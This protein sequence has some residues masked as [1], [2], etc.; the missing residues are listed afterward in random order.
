MLFYTLILINDFYFC[1]SHIQNI[2]NFK[3]KHLLFLFNINMM[4]YNQSGFYKFKTN[5]LPKVILNKIQNSME[6]YLLSSRKHIY[7]STLLPFFGVFYFIGVIASIKE[8]M[9]VSV[10]L[11]SSFLG[12]KIM[13]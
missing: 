13:I 11:S 4:I 8:P 1:A 3:N 9:G 5:P 12:I 10:G 2:K 7:L 6:N